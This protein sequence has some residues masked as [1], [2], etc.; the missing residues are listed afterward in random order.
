MLKK[1]IMKN[2]KKPFVLVTGATGFLGRRIV[3]ALFARGF[4]VRVFVRKTSRIGIFEKH[5]VDIAVGNMGDLESLRLAFDGIDCVVHAAADTSGTGDGGKAITMNGTQNIINLCKTF[6]IKKLVYISSV[7]VY[8]VAD[9]NDGDLVDE[10]S[11]LERFPEKRGAYSNAKFQAEQIVLEAMR[12]DECPIT[13]LR[14]GTIYGQGG[15]IYTP[16]MGFSYKNKLFLTIG[17]GKFILPLVYVDNVA[18]AVRAAIE[19][20]VSNGRVYNLIDPYQLTKKQYIRLLMKKIYPG[21]LFLNVPYRLLYL[22]VYIQGVLFNI[23]HIPAFLTRYRLES[24]QKEIV[25]SGE[26]VCL[27]LDW[28]PPVSLESALNR[29]IEHEMEKK[30][31]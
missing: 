31:K 5:T 30:N 29:M 1:L 11:P 13:C 16:M 20:T 4:R 6:R 14:P 15:E 23:I 12:Q 22:I 28:I 10:D 24:S 19:N 27:E 2:N 26:R 25:Y 17:K 8:G 7:S 9:Y 3:S 18:D 21:A